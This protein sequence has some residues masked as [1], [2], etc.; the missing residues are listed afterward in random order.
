MKDNIIGSSL[1]QKDN[2]AKLDYKQTYFLSDGN[3]DAA[4]NLSSYMGVRGGYIDMI[5]DVLKYSKALQQGGPCLQERARG[6]PR[7][8]LCKVLQTK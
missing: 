7:E 3:Y 1:S 8:P 4:I 6:S 5:H 2:V